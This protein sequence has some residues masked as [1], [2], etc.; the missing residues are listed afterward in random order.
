MKTSKLL[1]E[2]YNNMLEAYEDIENMLYDVEFIHK[3]RVNIREIRSLLYFYK[4]LL[5]KKKYNKLNEFLKKISA[6]FSNLREIQIAKEIYYDY[7][8]KKDIPYPNEFSEI[9]ISIEEAI[10][11]DLKRNL[12]PIEELEGKKSLLYSLTKQIDS[13][14][15]LKSFSKKR[16]RNISQK[17]LL[18]IKELDYNNF[19]NVHDLRINL[20]KLK[21]A[22]KYL[23]S[24]LKD[25]S[26]LP[27]NIVN[28]ISDSLGI[29]LDKHS[30]LNIL[31]AYPDVFNTY[32]KSYQRGLFEGYLYGELNEAKSYYINM[33][34]M[35]DTL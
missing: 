13:Y 5:K 31:S 3:F 18:E 28:D 7:C 30:V 27:E 4:P 19:E 22:L 14:D 11:S 12:V 24:S 16:M 32:H 9:L 1:K 34:E 25:F 8:V 23:S 17:I 21:Y 15:D 6:Q 10:A 35:V 26:F 2:K 29:I 20:K 33:K